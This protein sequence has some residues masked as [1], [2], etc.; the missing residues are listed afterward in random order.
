MKSHLTIFES[1]YVSEAAHAHMCACI[2]VYIHM[3][4]SVYMYAHACAHVCIDVCMQPYIN[5]CVQM[6]EVVV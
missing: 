5:V 3:C 1:I 6:Q 4:A 2:Y